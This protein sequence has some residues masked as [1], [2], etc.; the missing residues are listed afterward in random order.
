MKRVYLNKE[1]QGCAICE[2]CGRVQ[3]IQVAESARE[4]TI[5]INCECH[6]TFSVRIDQRRHYRKRVSLPGTF[7]RVYPQNSE[8]GRAIF[9][10]L[11]QTGVGF[12][13]Y[14]KQKVK[15]DD[16]L[17]LKFTLDDPHESTIDVRGT[18]KIVNDQ[19]V[20]VELD[21]PNEHTQKILGFYLMQDDG[22]RKV[23]EGGSKSQVIDTRR[24]LEP[25]EGWNPFGLPPDRG[26]DT[27]GFRGHLRALSGA[28]LLRILA[29]EKKTGVLQLLRSDKRG[30]LCFRE[31]DIVAVSGDG[32]QRLGEVLVEKGAITREVLAHGLA[33][34][35]R[36]GRR[37]G[38]ILLGSGF[39]TENA[40]RELV[41]HHV[42]ESVQ[43]LL[44]WREGH[45][46]YQDC[47]VDF[48]AIGVTPVVAGELQNG[49]RGK[50]KKREY[51]RLPV[52]WP[53]SILTAAGPISGEIRNISLTGALVYCRQLPNPKHFHRL[54]IEI[55]KYGHMMLLTVEMIRLDVVYV[56]YRGPIYSIGTRFV[57][58]D[59]RDLEFLSTKI[60]T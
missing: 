56:D 9:K 34:A 53:V 29:D 42:R 25:Q 36:S 50:A 32:W 28:S 58:I 4:Q 26:R 27:V 11:S 22:S 19:Y 8:K 1:R 37:L 21:R 47:T 54:S 13:T 33:L 2:K 12:L 23:R 20:G 24:P 43:D 44:D 31:G 57:E 5:E 15:V 41:H 35:R 46:E 30:A 52:A 48:P 3:R 45:F 55:K 49:F 16:V 6:H 51:S 17:K 38:E 10:D 59:E 18:V 7:E 14:A 39:V 60:V 40:I